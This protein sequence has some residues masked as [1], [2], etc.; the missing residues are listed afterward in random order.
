MRAAEEAFRVA[1]YSADAAQQIFPNNKHK[2]GFENDN[3][4][5]VECH[6]L[7]GLGP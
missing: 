2:N 5:V 4:T 3:K 7:G 6:R 1:A